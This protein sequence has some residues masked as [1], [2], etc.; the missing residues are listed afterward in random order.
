MRKILQLRSFAHPL[1]KHL[2]GNGQ[3]IFLWMDHWHPIGPLFQHY[4]R[5][6][7]YN[8]GRSLGAKVPSII[9]HG[10]WV[11]PR[12]MNAVTQEIVS[13][14]PAELIP[15]VAME[16]RVVWLPTSN[17][18]F[19]AKSAWEA[20]RVANPVVD[21]AP[22]V[23]FPHY[24]P[25]WSF[26]LWLVCHGRLSAKDRLCAWG[27]TLDEA[28]ILCLVGKE[29]HSHLFFACPFSGSI[30]DHF[31]QKYGYGVCSHNW[32]AALQ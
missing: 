10:A 32:D 24:V 9:S 19:S 12:A 28:C 29:S 6:V 20:I 17:G 5:R 14:T 3:S 7:V 13:L 30:L 11:G 2:I 26:I 1:I 8:M 31:M 22:V 15:H 27:V 4:G 18:L 25:R 16:D 23:W 21:W